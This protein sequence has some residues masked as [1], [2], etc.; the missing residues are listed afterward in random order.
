VFYGLSIYYYTHLFLQE[1][2]D[3]TRKRVKEDIKESI[4]AYSDFAES[5]LPKLKRAYLRKCQE[6]EVRYVLYP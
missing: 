1:T 2:Q 4:A 5:Q 3:R 6:V